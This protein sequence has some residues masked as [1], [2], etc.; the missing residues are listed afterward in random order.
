MTSPRYLERLSLLS[1]FEKLFEVL[2]QN[3]CGQLHDTVLVE[4]TLAE[5]AHRSL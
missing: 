4:L 3:R 5:P 1:L 2:L